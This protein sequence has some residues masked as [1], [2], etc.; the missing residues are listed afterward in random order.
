MI[1]ICG[2]PVTLSAFKSPIPLIFLIFEINSAALLSKI[3]KSSPKILMAISLRLPVINSLKRIWI[4]CEI[5]ILAPGMISISSFMAFAKSSQLWYLPF[6]SFL[7][8]RTIIK[9]P[10]SIGIGSVGISPLPILVTIV[11]I[12]GNLAFNNFSYFVVVS[13]IC[14]SE[15]PVIIVAL[16]AKSPSSIVGIN[17]PPIFWKM[18]NAKTKNPREMPKTTFL[19]C[20]ALFKKG[21]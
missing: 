14:V 1:V 4:G 8:F 7:S 12:S 17:S 3:S 9:S 21:V 6:H 15:L 19:N 16:I 10:L 13:T 18:I 11:L 5:S 2:K 20:N